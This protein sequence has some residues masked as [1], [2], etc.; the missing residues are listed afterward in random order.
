MTRLGL[1]ASLWVSEIAPS[2]TV[3]LGSAAAL[4]SPVSSSP[5]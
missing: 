1:A 5:R 4:M 3:K 2:K